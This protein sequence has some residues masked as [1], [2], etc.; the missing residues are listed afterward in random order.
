M[1]ALHDMACGQCGAV[2]ANAPLNVDGKHCSACGKGL[3]EILWRTSSRR[4]AAVHSSE[5]SVVWY[6]PKEGK[7]QF[8]GRNDEPMPDRLRKR[9]YERK[10]LPSLRS[11]EQFEK[12]ANVASEVAWFD[13]GSGNSFDGD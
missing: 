6:S 11:I 12:Q 3:M 1:A 4:D 9:G 8:P 5:R 7:H 13:R 2:Q 10:E